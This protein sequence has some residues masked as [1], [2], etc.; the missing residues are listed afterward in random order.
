MVFTT[1]AADYRLVVICSE[2]SEKKS[3]IITRL[4][5]NRRPV[6]PEL[7]VNDCKDYLKAHFVHQMDMEVSQVNPTLHLRA[8]I[9][10][11]DK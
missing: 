2:N 1:L 10:D 11:P 3:H 5:N 9:V 6:I 8:S 7:I 4:G